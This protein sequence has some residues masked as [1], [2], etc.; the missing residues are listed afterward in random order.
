M[1]VTYPLSLKV[2]VWLLLN[3][4]LLAGLGMGFFVVQGGLGWDALVAGPSGE[5]AQATANIIVGE[6]AGATAETRDAVLARLGGTYQ[7]E[8]FLYRMAGAKIAGP[9]VELPAEVRSRMESWQAPRGPGG[10]AARGEFGPGRSGFKGGRGDQRR[11]SAAE[12]EGAANL[13]LSDA[14]RPDSPDP[15]RPAPAEGPEQFKGPPRRG[16]GENAGREPPEF[17]RGRGPF[18]PNRDATRGRFIV[19]AGSPAAY[20]VGL[21]VPFASVERNRF[22]VPALLVARVGSLWYLLRFL[23]LHAWLLVG[24][25]V[26][27]LSVLFWLPLMSGITHAVRDLTTATE[28]IADGRFDT[29]VPTKRRD[30]LGKLGESVNRMATRLDTHMMGQKRFLGDV[31]H[32]LCSPLARLQMASGILAERAPADLHATVADVR[33]EVQQMSTLVNELLEFTKAGLQRREVA[34]QKLALGPVVQE[35]ITR[36]D[37]TGRTTL[38]ISPEID[39]LAERDLLSR[40]LGN[41]IRNAIRYAGDAG[42]IQVTARRDGSRVFIAVEDEGPGVPADA[43]DRL[44]EP[45]F[46]PEAA[47]TRELGGVGLGLAIV[48]SSIVACGGEVRFV[49]RSPRGFRAEL[50]LAAA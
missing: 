40:A 17:G 15:N 2:S 44:G 21:R 8:F 19:R 20:W 39:V 22:P 11:P 16:P 10:F 29:R 14:G 23:D 32:E 50:L 47:R 31:A 33:E 1:K 35:V 25:G 12:A 41:L 13:D 28:Q 45:F 36:E 42:P 43:I 48:R 3:L 6:A 9:N 18:D 26:L 49:N 38:N 4:L 5:R 37:P 7:A 24:T 46:R 34:R 27:A 30:E